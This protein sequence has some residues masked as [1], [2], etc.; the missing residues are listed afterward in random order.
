MACQVDP[1]DALRAQLRPLP[2]PTCG[3]HEL[4]PMLQCGYY[5]DGCVWLVQD[6]PRSDASRLPGLDQVAA[7]RSARHRTFEKPR[8]R[9]ELAGKC[10]L[11]HSGWASRAVR[12]DET[13]Q[14]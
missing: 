13:I 5:P 14:S 3:S 4:A 6:K 10:K 2:C 8:Q 9:L 7:I 11:A 12:C 1:V